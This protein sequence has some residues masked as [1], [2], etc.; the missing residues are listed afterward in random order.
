MKIKRK[1]KSKKVF[2]LAST[3]QSRIIR[4][5][6]KRL[7]PNSFDNADSMI[8]KPKKSDLVKEISRSKSNPKRIFRFKN[9]EFQPSTNESTQ[10]FYFQYRRLNKYT[11][12]LNRPKKMNEKEKY[13]LPAVL[14]RLENKNLLPLKSGLVKTSCISE[15]N[16]SYFNFGGKY[17]ECM[18]QSFKNKK[19]KTLK[20]KNNRL[21]DRSSS[22]VI[23]RVNNMVKNIDIS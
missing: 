9:R 14:K 18:S 20:L 19:F 6:Q 15:I 3:N 4:K 16:A 5:Y 2:D 17:A 23:K 13:Y 21:T 11:E 12:D 1:K 8:G 22:S 10:E 7:F